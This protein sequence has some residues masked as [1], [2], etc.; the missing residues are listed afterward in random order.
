MDTGLPLLHSG[1]VRDV[2]DAGPDD[3]GRARLLMVASDRISAFDVIM[4]EPIP[5]KGRILTAISAHWFALL[6]EVAP[7]HLLSTDVADFPETARRDELIGRSMLTRSAEMLPIE[8]IA[9]GYI[10]G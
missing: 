1:K 2:Y 9:R 6:A 4:D 3:E 5:D 10:T 7:S 8:C